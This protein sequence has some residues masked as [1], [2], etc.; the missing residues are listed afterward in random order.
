[1]GDMKKPKQPEP[2]PRLALR[3]GIVAVLDVPGEIPFPDVEVIV[4]RLQLAAPTLAPLFSAYYVSRR[5][6][7]RG[8]VGKAPA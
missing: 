1:M 8:G 6:R 3:A 5:K 7:A 2:D 4:D